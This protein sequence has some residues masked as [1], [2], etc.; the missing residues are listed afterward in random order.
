MLKAADKD[1][2]GAIDRAEMNAAMSKMRQGGGG[3]GPP[4]GGGGRGG[5]HGGRPGGSP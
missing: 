5:Q 4:G 2:D 1:G 3:G